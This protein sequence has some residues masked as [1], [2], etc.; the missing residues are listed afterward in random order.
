MTDEQ[1][2]EEGYAMR[3]RVLGDSHVD[4]A[5]NNKTALNSSFQNFITRYA[6]GEIWT[7]EKLDLRM[8]SLI[9]V[10]MLIA[11]NRDT[12][13]AMHFR[14]ALRNGVTEQ[15]LS[16]VLLHSSLYCGLPAAN[17]AYHLLQKTVDEQLP[18]TAQDTEPTS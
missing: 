5:E 18:R 1:R 6:W 2:L 9:T 17:A 3:R 8:R 10:A 7:R 12:E 4:N 14:A 15:D 16:E 13:L 11:L